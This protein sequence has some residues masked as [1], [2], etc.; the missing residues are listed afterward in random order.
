MLMLPF[1]RGHVD[2]GGPEHLSAGGRNRNYILLFGADMEMKSSN[3]K[4]LMV[5]FSF[6]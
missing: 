4:L 3:I 2:G 1:Y 5:I 6:S